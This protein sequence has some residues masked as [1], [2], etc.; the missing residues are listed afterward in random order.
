M[1]IAK[2]MDELTVYYPKSY[3]LNQAV[4]AHRQQNKSWNWV[5]AALN[6]LSTLQGAK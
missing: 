6:L 2:L 5:D 4:Y 1:T 3:D